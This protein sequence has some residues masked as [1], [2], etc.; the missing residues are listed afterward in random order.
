M[1]KRKDLDLLA[2]HDVSAG[3]CWDMGH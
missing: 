1:R 2:F 3:C